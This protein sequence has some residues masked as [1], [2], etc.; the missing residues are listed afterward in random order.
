MILKNNTGVPIV[1][2]GANDTIR[3]MKG[4]VFEVTESEMSQDIQNS[5]DNGNLLRVEYAN[6]K[7]APVKGKKKSKEVNA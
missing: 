6:T 3:L 2:D 4:E 1:L 5:I 7:K